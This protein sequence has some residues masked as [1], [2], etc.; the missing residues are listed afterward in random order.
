MNMPR[1]IQLKVPVHVRMAVK[2]S[3]DSPMIAASVPNTDNL[4]FHRFKYST[5]KMF[6]KKHAYIS[7]VLRIV[8][9]ILPSVDVLSAVFL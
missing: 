5:S 4:S 7:F 9:I 6:T 3:V 2:K 8:I 1:V